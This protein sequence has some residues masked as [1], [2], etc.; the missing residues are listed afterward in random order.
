M[1]ALACLLGLAL[2]ALSARALDL[3]S[4]PSRA[5]KPA[6]A[7]VQLMG[8]LEQRI[9]IGGETTGWVLRYD[10]EQRVDLLL[11]VDAFAWI[12]D[13]LVVAVKGRFET[14]HYPERGEV[15]VFVV[16]DINQVVT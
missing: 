3:P 6:A 2:A 7:E 13:G 9:A 8:T 16:R 12:R 1:K 5:E 4:A 14:R 11:P 10:K 15:R